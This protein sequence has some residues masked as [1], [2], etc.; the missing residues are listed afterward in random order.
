MDRRAAALCDQQFTE[1]DR[2]GELAEHAHVELARRGLDLAGGDLGMLAPDRGE[3]VLN[4][5]LLGAHLVRV[6]PDAQVPR[7]QASEENI[8]DARHGLELALEHILRVHHQVLDRH[9]S[10]QGEPQ[11]GLVLGI[12]LGDDGRFDIAGQAQLGLRDLG[13]DLLKGDVHAAVK[14]K[15][16]GNR[17]LA[18]LGGGGYLLDALNARDRVLDHVD[19]L[20]LHDLGRGAF[21]GHGDVDY[22]EVHVRHLGD[23]HAA[24]AHPAENHEEEHQH[25]GENRIL[26]REI[27]N[28]HDCLQR[29]PMQPFP[30]ILPITAR[31]RGR[32]RRLRAARGTNRRR[33]APRSAAGASAAE[34]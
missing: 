21:P 29:R 23:A 15:L 4:R 33:C 20:G 24:V 16:N 14:F 5:D 17:R 28:P 25:P 18:E 34:H 11:D 1:L 27:G 22:G 32:P 13:L 30:R 2:V 10:G 19:D 12:D 3:H 6:E 8:A 9:V 26:D 31:L 7:D